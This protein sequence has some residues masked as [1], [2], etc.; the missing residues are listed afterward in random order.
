M[1]RKGR[2]HANTDKKGLKIQ[3]RVGMLAFDCSAGCAVCW[4]LRVARS[5]ERDSLNRDRLKCLHLILKTYTDAAATPAAAV[6]WLYL[7]A[8]KLLDIVGSIGCLVG[9]Q[10]RFV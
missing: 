6:A 9:H 7:T 3:I 8:V 1:G 4:V 2:G 5:G 10:T